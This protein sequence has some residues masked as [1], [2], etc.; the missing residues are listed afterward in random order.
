MAGKVVVSD[1]N[2]RKSKLNYNQYIKKIRLK[3]CLTNE[4]DLIKLLIPNNSKNVEIEISFSPF[5]I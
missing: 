3:F 1:N 4:V 2:I 5:Q